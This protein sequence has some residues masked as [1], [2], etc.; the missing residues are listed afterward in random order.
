MRLRRPAPRREL[1]L[2]HKLKERGG[3]RKVVFT[4][5]ESGMK[6]EDIAQS[7]SDTLGERIAH[8]TLYQWIRRWRTEKKEEVAA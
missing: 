4:H 8:D 7:L 2:D 5:L 3:V 1:A 6:I